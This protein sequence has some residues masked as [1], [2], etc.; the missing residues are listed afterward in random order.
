[1][2]IYQFEQDVHASVVK[3]FGKSLLFA[4]GDDWHRQHAVF[5][6]VF[7]PKR[8]ANFVP[9]MTKRA[10]S[11]VINEFMNAAGGGEALQLREPMLSFTLDVLSTTVLGSLR[12]K[13]PVE[14]RR[15]LEHYG[16][17]FI[18]PLLFIPLLRDFPFPLLS[19]RERYHVDLIKF[20]DEAINECAQ[21]RRTGQGLPENKKGLIHLTLDANENGILTAEE[22]RDNMILFFIAG[23]E[24]HDNTTWK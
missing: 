1:M 12:L 6:D 13:G 14:L 21:Q 8:L 22:V 4:N 7:T 20:I 2:S 16:S 10:L 5:S 19:R 24:V 3:L 17:L 18:H 11:D 23:H 9:T 15:L